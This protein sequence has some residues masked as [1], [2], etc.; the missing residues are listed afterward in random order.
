M[1]PL[2]LTALA[3]STLFSSPAWG[4]NLGPATAGTGLTVVEATFS[5]E[6]DVRSVQA[7]VVDGTSGERTGQAPSLAWLR[8][9]GPYL[10]FQLAPLP[11]FSVSGKVGLASPLLREGGYQG[12]LHGAFGADARI[13][14]I[15]VAGGKFHAGLVGQFDWIR[16]LSSTEEGGQQVAFSSMRVAGGVGMSMGGDLSGFT[17]HVAVMYSFLDGSLQ[18]ADGSTRYQLRTQIPIGAVFGAEM[19]SEILNQGALRPGARLHAGLELR[20]I[21]TWGVGGRVGI[22]F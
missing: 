4:G 16:D 18:S 12:G 7:F 13:T 1:R 5:V 6:Y 22:S 20:A 21:D 19:N 15:H 11:Y 10:S 14:P 8:S 9:G 2:C 17:F 3:I